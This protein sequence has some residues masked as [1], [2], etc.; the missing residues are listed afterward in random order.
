MK[1]QADSVGLK[2]A[3]W[4]IIYYLYQQ[5]HIYIKLL[6]LTSKLTKDGAE[7]PKHVGAYS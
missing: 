6:N 7:A 4:F 3:H 5:L 1:L 2:K